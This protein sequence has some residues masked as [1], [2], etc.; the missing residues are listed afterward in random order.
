MEE[1]MSDGSTEA[2]YARARAQGNQGL[3][4][5]VLGGR[6]NCLLDLRK[7]GCGS[8]VRTSHAAGTRSVPIRQ[9]RGSENRPGDFDRDFNP[10]HDVNRARWLSVARARL[11]G[12]AL[13]PVALVQVGDV[14]FVRDGHHRISVA[15]ALGQTVVEATVEVWRVDGPLP[16][17]TRTGQPSGVKRIL[18]GFMR[19]PRP[20]PRER[21]A[22][23]EP[24]PS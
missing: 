1:P 20:G 15:R 7:I 8:G 23:L 2:L 4:R 13:P 22:P 24:A 17:D 19:H 12:R 3:L 5:S 9:I 6:S 18:A 11:R 14:Y 16:W 21:R 10:L